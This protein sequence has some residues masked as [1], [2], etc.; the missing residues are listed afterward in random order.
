MIER[1]LRWLGWRLRPSETVP[2][3][4]RLDV[5]VDGERWTPVTSLAGRAPDERVY[6]VRV[7]GDRET[8]TFGDGVTG[9]RPPDGSR[10]AS[11][12]RPG[13]GATG[14]VPAVDPAADPLRALLDL[15]ARMAD[16]LAAAQEQIA[17]EAFIE[18]ASGA[19][20]PLIDADAVRHAVTSED[21]AR[22]EVR[23]RFRP[24]TDRDDP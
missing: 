13:S 8:V 3:S 19:V 5:A 6:L 18:T 9:R 14:D 7:D 4:G 1:L 16:E 23:I 20:V 10:I 24:G 22:F 21:D 2:A 12:Y 15:L 17:N 11:T